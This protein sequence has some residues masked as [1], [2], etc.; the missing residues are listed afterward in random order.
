MADVTIQTGRRESI[1]ALR[2]R[3]VMGR[4]EWAPPRPWGPDSWA[5]T[6]V[7]GNG[8][9]V[10]SIAYYDGVGWVHASISRLRLPSYEDL[11][12]LHRAVFGDGHAYQ[13]FVPPDQHVNVHPRCLHLWGRADGASVLPGFAEEGVT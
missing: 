4:R 3:A 11:K 8:I 9:V 12:L 5:M 6:A 7:D 13:A 2:M 10:A 1:D